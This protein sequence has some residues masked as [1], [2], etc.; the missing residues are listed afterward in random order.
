MTDK[1]IVKTLNN[2]NN[3]SKS[4]LAFIGLVSLMAISFAISCPKVL[5]ELYMLLK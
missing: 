4:I 2:L 3:K 1:E 5:L